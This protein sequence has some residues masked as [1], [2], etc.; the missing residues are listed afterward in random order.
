MSIS[1]EFHPM[2]LDEE[3]RLQ[4]LRPYQLLNTMQDETFA[5][6][7]RLTAKLFHVPICIIALVEEDVVRFG[8]NHGLPPAMDRVNRWETLCSVALLEEGTTV[9]KDLHTEPCAL[10]NLSLVKHLNLG[11]YAGHALRTPDGQPIGV[12]CVID[13]QPR[14]FS[15]R[16]LALLEPLAGVIMSL[17][18]VRI[19]LTQQPRWN[20]ELWTEIYRRIE[21]SVTRLETL[22]ALA[23]WEEGADNATS[24]AYQAST[25]EEMLHVITVLHQQIR[26]ALR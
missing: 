26:A 9:F 19:A 22:A 12:L 13:H 4:A 8:L 17:L 1:P 16:D 11:F 25:Y 20:Q 21:T 7:V 6:L 10:I 24:Q 2:P 5:E 15:P 23:N 3:A 14:E 18:N